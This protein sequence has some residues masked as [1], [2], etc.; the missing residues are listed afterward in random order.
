M[1]LGHEGQELTHIHFQIQ[2]VVLWQIAHSATEM[3][4]SLTRCPATS[5]E[6]EVGG[7]K[8]VRIFIMV[9]FPAPF[10]P[11]IP[12]LSAGH[13]K[14]DPIQRLLY[15]VHLT[16]LVYTNRHSSKVTHS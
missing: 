9:L 4:S 8:A 7:R 2:W 15:S 1:N 11:K 6:P 14:T 3:G 10:G 16:D 5:T 12:R 13:L